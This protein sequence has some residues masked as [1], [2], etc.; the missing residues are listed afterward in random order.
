MKLQPPNIRKRNMYPRKQELHIILF[1]I[2]IA[3]PQISQINK[4][5]YFIYKQQMTKMPT[6]T[7]KTH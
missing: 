6:I 7:V 4:L 3:K 5:F 1:H 2:S